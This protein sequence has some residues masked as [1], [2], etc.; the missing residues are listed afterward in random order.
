MLEKQNRLAS[1]MSMAI[2]VLSVLLVGA[3]AGSSG[4]PEAE[5]SSKNVFTAPDGTVTEKAIEASSSEAESDK[6]GCTHIRF[7]DQPNSPN[8]IVC[9]TNDS[10]SGACS[11][12]ATRCFECCDDARTV[13]GTANPIT[14]DPGFPGTCHCG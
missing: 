6:A 4:R 1:R 10:T 5:S 3:F 14:F 8:V 13:C 2:A 12:P 11:D 7:C 9:D